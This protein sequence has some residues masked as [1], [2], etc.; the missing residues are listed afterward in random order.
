MKNQTTAIQMTTPL[1]V[2]KNSFFAIRSPSSATTRS[3][4]S[5]SGSLQGHFAGLFSMS[6]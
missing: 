1:N 2:M 3:S 6:M 4:V 5:R